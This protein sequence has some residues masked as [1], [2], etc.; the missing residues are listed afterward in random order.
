MGSQLRQTLAHWIQLTCCT[1][2][3]HHSAARASQAAAWPLCLQGPLHGGLHAGADNANAVLAEIYN[4]L[5]DVDFNVP[6]QAKETTTRQVQEEQLIRTR[7]K[8]TAV[9]GDNAACQLSLLKALKLACR[10][11][12]RNGT[13][14][15]HC[16]RM[17]AAHTKA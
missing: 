14:V 15:R 10:W 5:S 4:R 17:T 13:P 7:H 12:M 11:Y 1:D 2:Y 9:D 6:V 16:V 8:Q 3:C